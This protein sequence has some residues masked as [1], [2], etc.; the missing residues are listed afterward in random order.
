MELVR[1]LIRFNNPSSRSE[2]EAPHRFRLDKETRNRLLVEAGSLDEY[3]AS[4]RHLPAATTMMEAMDA[5]SYLKTQDNDAADLDKR[6]GHI[7]RPS[8]NFE[9]HRDTR[10]FS[11]EATLE[12][13]KFRV[14]GE[15]AEVIVSNVKGD[16]ARIEV[17]SGL[18]NYCSR[19][20]ASSP[21]NHEH[22]SGAPLTEP[23]RFFISDRGKIPRP[24]VENLEDAARSENHRQ[25]AGRAEEIVHAALHW[26]D[27]SS[28]L[29]GSAVDL[30]PNKGEVV[31]ADM[32]PHSS[33]PRNF[34]EALFDWGSP[35]Y[36]DFITE[37]ER[38]GSFW[39]K[40]H[41]GEGHYPR[42][43]LEIGPNVFSVTGSR[44]AGERD[45]EAPRLSAQRKGAVLDLTFTYPGK[46]FREE[47][48]W[49]KDDNSVSYQ[50][51]RLSRSS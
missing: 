24:P 32:N 40:E 50:K 2:S 1:P 4:T 31:A 6:K 17:K 49:N 27:R 33:Y 38:P 13:Q 43:D 41:S 20:R 3:Y 46:R 48:I 18:V 37:G 42:R 30:N 22:R 5:V 35:R 9:Y 8:D 36:Y 51:F 14:E 7:V 39:T 16:V 21:R 10:L 29:D 45:V 12:G 25:I 44:G 34:W 19:D 47:V 23:F 11:G 15:D 26:L 28:K